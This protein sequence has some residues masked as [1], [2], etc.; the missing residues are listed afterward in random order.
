MN[1]ETM[2]STSISPPSYTYDPSDDEGDANHQNTSAVEK[3]KRSSRAC[4]QCRKTKSKCQRVP[5]NP[6][7]RNCLSLNQECTF[8]GPSRKRGP[9]KGY[10]TQLETRVH[11]LEAL[12]G[13]LLASPDSRAQ[14]LVSDL[15]QDYL[16][17]DILADVEAG[18]FGPIG[19]VKVMQNHEIDILNPSQ[20]QMGNG[21]TFISSKDRREQLIV[22]NEAD[23]S[24][25]SYNWQDGL[26]SYLNTRGA[27]RQQGDKSGLDAASQINAPYSFDIEPFDNILPNPSDMGML[28]STTRPNGNAAPTTGNMNGN[29]GSSANGSGRPGAGRSEMTYG[30]LALPPVKEASLPRLGSFSLATRRP[31][32]AEIIWQTLYDRSVPSSAEEDEY[33]SDDPSNAMGQL[34]L[35]EKEQVGFLGKTS[36]MHLLAKPDRHDNLN[37]GG[38]WHLPQTRYWPASL[39]GRPMI[40]EDLNLET[41]L[42][43]VDIQ[44][45]LLDLYWTYVQPVLP[46]LDKEK[47]MKEYE[48]ERNFAASPSPSTSPSST[49]SAANQSAQNH[50]HRIPRL[51]LLSMFTI[52]A[53]YSDFKL[54]PPPAK[55][56]MWEAGCEYLDQAKLILNFTYDSPRPSTC[57]ALLLLAYREFGLGAISQAWIYMGMAMRMATD[58][59]MHRAA[60]RWQRSGRILFTESEKSSRKRIWHACVILDRIMAFSMGRPMCI[61]ERDYDTTSPP[62]DD[63]A[64]EELEA[65]PPNTR[66]G[67]TPRTAYTISTFNSMSSLSSILALIVDTIYA[68]RSGVSFVLRHVESFKIAKMLEEW[69]NQIPSHLRFDPR[70]AAEIYARGSIGKDKSGVPLPH[71][72]TLHMMYWVTVL[73]VHRPFIRHN[74]HTHTHTSVPEEEISHM[75]EKSFQES[76]YAASQVSMLVDIYRRTWDLSRASVFI[77]WFVLSAGVMHVATL[78]MK[79][80]NQEEARLG[81]QCCLDAL[82]QMKIV[83][84][85][86]QRAWQ[87]LHG[88]KID[89]SLPQQASTSDIGQRTALAAQN[90]TPVHPHSTPSPLNNA[91]SRNYNPSHDTTRPPSLPVYPAVSHPQ[92]TYPSL[93]IAMGR[94]TS[95]PAP[96]MSYFPGYDYW[97]PESLAFDPPFLNFGE[98]EDVKPP[99][100]TGPSQ[101]PTPNHLSGNTHPTPVP[102]FSTLDYGIGMGASN[103]TGTSAGLNGYENHGAQPQGGMGRSPWEYYSQNAG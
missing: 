53:R 26:I 7:C 15:A 47:F 73:L 67:T 20:Q 63:L 2:D 5:G 14:T 103:H 30:G 35:N 87:L 49:T 83:W 38:I 34:A 50:T 88:A 98:Q 16:A 24:L 32:D 21:R 28:S 78:T 76:R 17:R 13:I 1:M 3:R 6:S 45:Q 93:T 69:Y 12:W 48:A 37:N 60:D 27:A 18:P 29:G 70:V 51:L 81:L 43:T 66:P 92:A 58:L 90:L 95:G 94:P 96:A 79:K 4:D 101:N 55:G 68:C 56:T 46:V 57:Q 39:R 25:P 85:S 42:P 23:P 84:P 86:S 54:E 99:H 80:G 91:S 11:R 65:W 31:Q 59:G 33:D 40:E 64:G 77:G 72:L 102:G 9:P 97:P 75:S 8:L 41:R 19:R 71:V 61:R 52:A 100:S 74:N 22:G 10:I 44:R 82:Y 62:A 89:L 36:G